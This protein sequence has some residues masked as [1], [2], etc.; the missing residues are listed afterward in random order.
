MKI[1]VFLVLA[2]LSL[3][4]P[5]DSDTN[6][7]TRWQCSFNGLMK[8]SDFMQKFSRL[9]CDYEGKFKNNMQNFEV[10][11]NSLKE[12]LGQYGCNLDEIL[13]T[14]ATLEQ[15]GEGAADI[16]TEVSRVLGEVLSALGIAPGLAKV[17]CKLTSGALFS[18]CAATILTNSLPSTNTKLYDLFCKDDFTALSAYDIFIFFQNIGCFVDDALGTK[19]TVE[20]LFKKFGDPLAPLLQNFVISLAGILKDSGVLKSG[21]LLFNIL[22][23]AGGGLLGGVFGGSLLGGGGVGGGAGGGIL[24]GGIVGS[25]LG[26]GSGGGSVGGGILGGLLAQKPKRVPVKSNPT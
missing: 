6:P 3:A 23:G 9:A 19:E 15:T 18:K 16:A 25:L 4:A 10:A 14:K 26:G 24:P 11:F 5:G 8:T 2:G 22:S 21:C 20:E 7:D 12:A 13:G 17:V 1:I